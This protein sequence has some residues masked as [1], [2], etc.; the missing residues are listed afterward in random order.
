M[1]RAVSRIKGT[2]FQQGG[3]CFC[4]NHTR[5]ALLGLIAWIS[6][7]VLT[8]GCSKENAHTTFSRKYR[9]YFTCDLNQPPFNQVTSPG[10]FVSIRI[11]MGTGFLD[12]KDLDGNTFNRPVSQSESKIFHMG[13]SG[14]ILGTPTLG[15]DAQQIWAYDLGCP[16][17]DRESSRLSLTWDGHA[18]CPTC[19][20]QFDLNNGGTVLS[21][22]ATKVRPLYRYPVNPY[23]TS[24]TVAN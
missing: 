19:K 5:K 12:M 11:N 21:S 24:V 18:H 16:I 9:V 2:R 4:F 10:R 15:N 20:S 14:I 13:L 8:A 23:G 1:K 3:W 22:T 7:A 17:C 6:I